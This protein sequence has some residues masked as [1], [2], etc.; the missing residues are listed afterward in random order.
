KV[1]DFGGRRDGAS[2][3]PSRERVV[4]SRRLGQPCGSRGKYQSDILARPRYGTLSGREIHIPPIQ[5]AVRGG[6]GRPA[7]PDDSAAADRHARQSDRRRELVRGAQDEVAEMI[8]SPPHGLR[9]VIGFAGGTALIV[10]TD[11]DRQ[12]FARSTV[13][14][15]RR[16]G[17]P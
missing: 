17:S 13:W 6:P 8:Q 7:P 3:V 4:L 5:P 10:G 14:P 15:L 2:L 12:L 1:G 9:R 16:R 11:P